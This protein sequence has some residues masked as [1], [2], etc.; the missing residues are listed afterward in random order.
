M[1]DDL[2]K[3][4]ANIERLPVRVTAQ[5][6]AVAWRTS[7]VVRTRAQQ[8]LRSQTHGTGKTAN[9]IV[10]VEQA[11]KKQ[12]LVTVENPDNPELGLWLERGTVHMRARPFMRPAGDEATAGYVREMTEAATQAAEDSFT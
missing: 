6:R 9:S 2:A 7:R 11:E 5:L 12:F 4:R 8:I 10:I 3:L 1:A